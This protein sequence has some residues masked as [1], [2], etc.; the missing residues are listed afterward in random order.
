MINKLNK[1]WNIDKNNEMQMTSLGYSYFQS[2]K[3][4]KAIDK[5][6]RRNIK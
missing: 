1:Y 6:N 4:Y 3:F 5:L 2:S